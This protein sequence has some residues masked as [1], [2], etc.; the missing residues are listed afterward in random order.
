LTDIEIGLL[1]MSTEYNKTLE[2]D[3]KKDGPEL[4]A[5]LLKVL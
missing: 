4:V 3:T 1:D 2:V 5:R